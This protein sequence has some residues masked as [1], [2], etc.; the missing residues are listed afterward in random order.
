MKNM[1]LYGSQIPKNLIQQSNGTMNGV[2]FIGT[3]TDDSFS[4][5]IGGIK[6]V[7]PAPVWFDFHDPYMNRE[8]RRA[9]QYGRTRKEGWDNEQRMKGRNRSRMAKAARWH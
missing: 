3:T 5:D 2:I 4:F 6:P 9:A 8:D 1:I 7:K